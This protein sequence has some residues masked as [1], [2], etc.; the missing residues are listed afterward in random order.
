MA[1]YRI[2]KAKSYSSRATKAWDPITKWKIII[3]SHLGSTKVR[4]CIS[5][6]IWSCIVCVWSIYH[7]LIEVDLSKL[8]Y[9]AEI[10]NWFVIFFNFF[11][12]YFVSNNITIL[13]TLRKCFQNSFSLLIFNKNNLFLCFNFK[14]SIE[15]MNTQ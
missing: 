11:Y 7:G 15:I 4:D 12:F 2:I 9:T 6:S 14:F 10:F 5:K 8:F 3:P 13:I 1:R